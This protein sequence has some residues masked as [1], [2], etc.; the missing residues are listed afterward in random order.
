MN[1]C[2]AAMAATSTRLY[3]RWRQSGRS[4]LIVRLSNEKPP[5]PVLALSGPPDRLKRCL[6]LGV[7][8]T[9][10]S[11]T[12]QCQLLMLWRPLCRIKMQYW[13]DAMGDPNR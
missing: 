8:R 13:A 6:L 10:A 11:N 1:R 4:S 12:A 9:S 2:S 5:C 7:K 3:A